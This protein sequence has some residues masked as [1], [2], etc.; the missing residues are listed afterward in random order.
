MVVLFCKN[1][2][3]PQLEEIILSIREMNDPV[4]AIQ[5]KLFTSNY[6]SRVVQ[7][8]E[9]FFV[10]NFVQK[11]DQYFWSFSYSKSPLLWPLLR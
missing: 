6:T 10:Q 1:L 9:A 4:M 8:F 2:K 5:G 7:A 3:L 11:T